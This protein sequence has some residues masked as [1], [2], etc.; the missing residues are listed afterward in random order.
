[1]KAVIVA[2]KRTPIGKVRGALRR[3]RVEELAA[4]VL[5]ALLADTKITPDQ[6]DDVVLG[7]AAGPGGN[8]ARLTALQAGFPVSVP[9][10]TVD[11]QCGSGLEAINMAAR[12]I[13]AGAGEI[14]I[15]GGVES[16]ST[17]PLRYE[18][19]DAAPPKAFTRAR[20]A[21]DFV[22]D[23][24]MGAAAEN[25]ARA[26]NITRARQDAFA[27]R[28]HQKAVAAMAE[29]RFTA[30]IVPVADVNADECPRADT[31]LEK[32]SAL[33][34]V[35]TEH[36]T[37]TAGNACPVNDGAAAVLLMSEAKA[38]ALGFDEGLRV[39]DSAVAGVDPSLLGI[40]P[41]PAVKKLLKRQNLTLAD[42]DLVEFNEAFAAQVLACRDQ[43][44][45]MEDQLNVGGGAVALGHPYGASG[46][47]LMVRL[48]TELV[49]RDNG[50]R[51]LATLGIGG[52]MGLATVVE[53]T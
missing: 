9:G 24:D 11:R 22:G 44:G 50:A 13:E 46:A 35:F 39:M 33:P 3:L 48:F 43:L 31:T 21:P 6:I 40:G 30:E 34:P 41:V 25:V 4:P 15:A 47:V 8:V 51:G 36:G 7:N 18:T 52:G 26:Y 28:S 12:L 49:R 38:K 10:V 16:S 19:S 14:Y 32:L 20:F 2:A 53:R 5:R 1:L 23:P 29:G 37:I 42:I 45:L 27:L 17:A